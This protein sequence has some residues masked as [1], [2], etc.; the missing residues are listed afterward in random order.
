MLRF[1]RPRLALAVAGLALLAAAAWPAVAPLRTAA[2][3]ALL[4]PSLF[5]VSPVRPLEWFGPAPVTETVPLRPEPDAAYGLI[6]RPPGDGPY[7]GIV[8]SLGVEPAPPDD[9]R[10]VTFTR[11]LA[12]HGFAVLL[13]VSEALDERRLEPHEVEVLVA[14]VRALQERP[15]VD[16]ARV[17]VAGFSVGGS[18]ALLA[19]ADPAV[20]DRILFVNAM[21]PYYRVEDLARAATTETACLDG[22]CRPWEPD[23]L[24]RDVVRSNLLATLEPADRAR[25]QRLLAEPGGGTGAAPPLPDP[26][27][28]VYA[29]LAAPDPARFDERFARLPDHQ[30]RKFQAL[31]PAGRL[32]GIRARVFLMHAAGDP[33]IPVT[34]SRRIL[35]EA[36]SAGVS[37]YYSETAIF[38]HVDLTGADPPL[39]LRD[40]V[41]LLAH[42]YFLLR[43]A[44]RGG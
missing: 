39:L 3:T 40:A 14:A 31:S 1:R 16:P 18:L 25:V 11:A 9:P 15:Y 42:V 23:R 38:E 44:E 12:R 41:K 21:G 35:A 2:R 29:M 30:V 26:A 24:T 20:R 13:V 17:G 5:A 6:V 28:A 32:G 22:A 7:P 8:V 33:Y 34:E 43:L 27:G 19:A 37:V 36:R 4:V 10:V